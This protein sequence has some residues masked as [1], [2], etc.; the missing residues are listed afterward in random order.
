MTLDLDIRRFVYI[1]KY[2]IDRIKIANDFVAQSVINKKDMQVVAA[3]IN[4]AKSMK[5][6]VTAKRRGKPRDKRAFK[7]A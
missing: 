6:K 5:L 4:I 1:R 7:R 3:I 2:K